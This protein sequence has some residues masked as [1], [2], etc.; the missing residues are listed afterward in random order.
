MQEALVL[1]CEDSAAGATHLLSTFNPVIVITLR[2][3]LVLGLKDILERHLQFEEAVLLENLIGSDGDH[4]QDAS[5]QLLDV[6]GVL[7]G[8]DAGLIDA[9]VEEGLVY[10]VLHDQ[11]VLQLPLC[12]LHVLPEHLQVCQFAL[13]VL[14]CLVYC[15]SKHRVLSQLVI[16]HLQLLRC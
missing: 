11:Q 9:A 3:V 6:L 2:D 16:E 13:Q 1:G 12:Q 14:P 4:G 8:Q 15:L 10:L 5:L 7:R